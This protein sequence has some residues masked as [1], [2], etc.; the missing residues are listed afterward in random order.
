VPVG[1]IPENTVVISAILIKIYLLES[2]ISFENSL[3]ALAGLRNIILIGSLYGFHGVITRSLVIENINEPFLVTTRIF[4]VTIIFGIYAREDFSNQINFD[5]FKKG[6][7]SGFLAIYLPGW[8]FIYALNFISSGL[9]SIFISTIPMFTLVWVYLFYKEEKVT[10]L[11]IISVIF[12]FIGLL[13]L[14]Q[15]GISGIQ[16]GGNLIF[17]GM[18][19]LIGVQGLAL[20]NITNRKYSQYIPYKTFMLTQWL[21]GSVMSVLTYIFVGGEISKLE[22]QAFIRLFALISIDVISYSLFLYT[23]KRISATFTTLVDY[24]VPVVGISAGFFFLGEFV[25]N[26]FFVTLMLIFISLFLA[27]RDESTNF[28]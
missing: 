10:K 27:V 14:F 4:C 16:N 3:S 18:L 17:G 8:T 6:A 12:G 28:K 7:L 2:L 21:T 23:I 1:C 11:K 25:D 20:S 24:I 9:N 19:S 13:I 22:T 15:S 26:I 5:Y